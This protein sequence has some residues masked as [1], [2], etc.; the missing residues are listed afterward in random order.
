MSALPRAGPARR[1][2]GAAS[3]GRERRAGSRRRGRPEGA[4]HVQ[5]AGARGRWAP[6]SRRWRATA[7]WATGGRGLRAHG[8]DEALEGGRAAGAARWSAEAALVATGSGGDT[9]GARSGSRAPR[10]AAAA[11]CRRR[12]DGRSGPRHRLLSGGRRH[13]RHPQAPWA[14]RGER[15]ASARTPPGPPSLLP[16]PPAFRNGVKGLGE[17]ARASRQPS[18]RSVARRRGGGGLVPEGQQRRRGEVRRGRVAL[19]KACRTEGNQQGLE[20]HTMK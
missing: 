12:R 17:A 15:E 6:G 4:P 13:R 14:A 16:K 3:R 9:A 2:P 19:S 10:R 1:A 7:W 8:P 18:S 20:A 11:L 5:A